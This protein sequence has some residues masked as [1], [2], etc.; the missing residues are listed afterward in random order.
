[1][2]SGDPCSNDVANDTRENVDQDRNYRLDQK[3]NN[4]NNAKQK[5]LDDLN[6]A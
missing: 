1:M 5:V 3:W 4:E 6:E 2:N